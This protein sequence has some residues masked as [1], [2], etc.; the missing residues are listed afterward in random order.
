[1]NVFADFASLTKTSR[2]WIQHSSAN[3]VDPVD[4]GN[5][6]GLCVP[7][8]NLTLMTT[9]F[10]LGLKHLRYLKEWAANGMKAAV[11]SASEASAKSLTGARAAQRPEAMTARG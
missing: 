6:L 7:A 4:V 2:Q 5:N 3:I 11:R 9:C 8:G 10:S 1:V